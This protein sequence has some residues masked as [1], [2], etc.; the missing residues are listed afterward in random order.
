MFRG[1]QESRSLTGWRHWTI[2]RYSRQEKTLG[3]NAWS[4]L[5][6]WMRTAKFF[7]KD[8]VN[9]GPMN[10]VNPEHANL[11]SSL[12]Y[13]DGGVSYHYPVLDIDMQAVLTPTSTPGHHHLF[14]NKLLTDEQYGKLLNTLV[15][16]G[17]VQQGILDLQWK[18][19]GM[20]CARMPGEVKEPNSLSSGGNLNTKP[21]MGQTFVQYNPSSAMQKATITNQSMKMDTVSASEVLKKIKANDG[22]MI[23]L[24]K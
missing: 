4:K 14:I 2:R 10:E 15:E 22:G 21:D 3:L 11:V 17:I 20:T 24:P 23:Q 8:L 19:D 18:Q 16:V 12:A 6:H 9:G 5:P 7:K 1:G 13:S